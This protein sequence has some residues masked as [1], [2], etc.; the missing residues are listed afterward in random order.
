M[1]LILPPHPHAR[2]R[3]PDPAVWQGRQT[4]PEAGLQ[5]WHQAVACVDLTG[6]AT[7]PQPVALLGYACDEGVRRNQGRV[8]AQAGP[9]ALRL[10]LAKL[11]YPHAPGRLADLG[12]VACEGSE[13]EACQAL[14]AGIVA[15]VVAAGHFPLVIGGGHDVAFGH[16]QGIRRGL[17]GQGKRL[18]IVNFDAHF[19]LRPV[20]AAPNSGTP[21]N[22]VLEAH[23][24]VGYLAVGIQPASNPPLLFELAEQFGAAYVLSEACTGDNFEAVQAILG[25]FA[26]RH[27]ALYLTIDLDGFAA[28]FAPGVSAPSP[29]G[30][31]PDFVW[32]ASKLLLA[33]G[34]VVAC[35]LAE[36]NPG[37]DRD[38]L[39]ANLAARLV[40]AVVERLG[41]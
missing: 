18:G 33:T 17:A 11:A 25:A 14:L 7:V 2:Y 30:F 9:L 31:A 28:P 26:Q 4:P 6:G 21:F 10:Q 8:G 29:L 23:P 37:Y 39:T 13:M 5:Y 19:D 41:K 22:Q 12:D 3:P 35:D 16:F 36:L 40:D 32:R 34:K 1:E 15:Q 20:A 27:D 24:E 38:G